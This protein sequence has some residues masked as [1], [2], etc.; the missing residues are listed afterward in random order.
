MGKAVAVLGSNIKGTSHSDL[1]LMGTIS[2]GCSTFVTIEG[3]PVA[4]VGSTTQE[5]DSKDTGTGKV[6]SGSNFVTIDGKPVAR[7][8][9]SVTP[10]SGYATIADG[11]SFV[12][13]E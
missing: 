3:K 5:W 9:D 6:S 4:I 8:G 2:G 11:I 7:V 13:I 10:H 1:Y 12:T